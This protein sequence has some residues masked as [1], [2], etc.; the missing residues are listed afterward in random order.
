MLH[1]KEISF[2]GLQEMDIKTISELSEA[3]SEVGLFRLVEHGIAADQIDD[4]FEKSHSFFT[5]LSMG[6]YLIS[7]IISIST[8]MPAGNEPIPTADLEP[9]PASPNTSTIRSENP[10]IT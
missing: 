10:F 9:L 7:T 8:E 5:L 3:C 6:V 2:R 4:F 1:I